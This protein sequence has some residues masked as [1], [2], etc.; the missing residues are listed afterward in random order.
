MAG[1]GAPEQVLSPLSSNSL[2]SYTNERAQGTSPGGE[3]RSRMSNAVDQ[4][5]WDLQTHSSPS[6]SSKL[7]MQDLSFILHP[8][9]EASTSEKDQSPGKDV[10]GQAHQLML[11]NACQS[12]GTS[13]DVAE[14]MYVHVVETTK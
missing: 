2:G 7:N 1:M 4:D 11:Q 14:N 9:H 6:R 5:G 12:L 10:T 13:V 3:S 8:C